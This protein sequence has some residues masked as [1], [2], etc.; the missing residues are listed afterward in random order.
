MSPKDKEPDPRDYRYLQF[1]AGRVKGLEDEDMAKHLHCGSAA[2]L[3]QRRSTDD[4]PVCPACGAARH[5]RTIAKN[6]RLDGSREKRG[7][8]VTFLRFLL[9][10]SYS[11]NASKPCRTP[12]ITC[13]AWWYRP[14][15]DALWARPYKTPRY[16]SPETSGRR[17][18]G[19]GVAR[20]RARTPLQ[21][22]SS[23]PRE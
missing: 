16:S 14:K 13:H 10:R 1:V 15:E 22:A 20:A 5:G 11:E 6:P 3:H 19:E 12:S 18:S 2:H 9:H 21:T 4:Y 7:S 23:S 8:R 17:T